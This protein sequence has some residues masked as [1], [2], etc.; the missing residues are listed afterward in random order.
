MADVQFQDSDIVFHDGDV[1][2]TKAQS[3]SSVSSNYTLLFQVSGV[4]PANNTVVRI[5][6]TYGM[7]VYGSGYF[8]ENLVTQT[9][10]SIYFSPAVVGYS[11]WVEAD[12]A[13]TTDQTELSPVWQNLL[14][15]YTVLSGLT[16]DKRSSAAQVVE[17][18]Y[19]NELNYL[20]QNVLEIIPNAKSD[21]VF[22]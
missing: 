6:A 8:V 9:G 14:V 15:L 13:N 22:K 17:Q 11:L 19:R 2:W 3:S 18:I 5:G 7:S 1:Q 12:Y 4:L 16:K 20:K 21:M 10:G